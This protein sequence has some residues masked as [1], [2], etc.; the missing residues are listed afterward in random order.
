MEVSKLE[1]KLKVKGDPSRTR[2]CLMQTWFQTRPT[3]WGIIPKEV[4]RFSTPH[5]PNFETAI[6]IIGSSSSLPL[7]LLIVDGIPIQPLCLV[8]FVACRQAWV[9]ASI[10]ELHTL[11]D[12]RS[13]SSV[14]RVQLSKYIVDHNCSVAYSFCFPNLIS[15]IRKHPYRR[16]ATAE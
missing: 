12:H 6:S 1:S 16:D 7:T 8:K 14:R 13:T 5:H 10:A 3:S 9:A 2:W 15:A 11:E 4:G